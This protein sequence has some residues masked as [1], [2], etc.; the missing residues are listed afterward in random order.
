MV[1]KPPVARRACALDCR[2]CAQRAVHLGRMR[3]KRGVWGEADDVLSVGSRCWGVPSGLVG[4]VGARGGCQLVRAL[5]P[6]L[7]LLSGGNC[8]HRG[9]TRRRHAVT[10]VL[11]SQNPPMGT[12]WCGGLSVLCSTC[13]PPR[14]HAPK[15]GCLGRSGRRF[16]RRFAMLGVCRR[17]SSVWSASSAWSAWLASSV[18]AVAGPGANRCRVQKGGTPQGPASMLPRPSCRRAWLVIH[19]CRADD[20]AGRALLPRKRVQHW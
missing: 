15:K 17:A 12:G 1:A 4:V 14:P 20:L 6:R 2:C 5:L 19:V 11:W 3:R 9:A 7:V 13:S 18:L 16:E 8:D 10:G